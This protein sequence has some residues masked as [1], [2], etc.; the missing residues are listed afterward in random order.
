MQK[1]DDCLLNFVTLAQSEC[2]NECIVY[3]YDKKSTI[4][5]FADNNIKVLK[6]FPLINAFSVCFNSTKLLQTASQNFVAYISSV[7]NV[8]ALMDISK[9]V[10]NVSNTHLTG[11]QTTIAFIDTGINPHLDFCLGKNRI[12]KFY[13][14]VKNATIMHDDNGHGTFVAGVACGNGACSNGKYAGVA[15]KAN[16]ISLKALNEK[17]E[18]TAISILEAMQ[19]VF[20][21]YKKYNIK[22]V[23]MSFGSEP[24]G[25][26]DPI[27]LGAER[28]WE[29]GIVVVCAGGNS[30]P[31]VQSIKSP[32]ISR[33]IITVGGLDDKRDD[34][35]GF[36]FNKFDIA[37]FSS[38]GPALNRVKPDII[39]PSV[40]ITSCS[41]LGG[42][43]QMS[44]TSVATPMVAGIACLIFQKYPNATPNQIKKYMLANAKSIY[45]NRFAQ[46][47][48]VANF[49]FD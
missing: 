37:E 20:D 38:R 22:V 35:G 4:K 9:K 14:F 33:K 1:I 44:G 47:Y 43:K 3:Y 48:G 28:L 42:Y 13:D 23:C 21:N 30:G 25:L 32:G 15:S 41:H 45:K 8:F 29:E 49:T 11:E 26:N 12:I 40:N 36:D 39:A 5:Y 2:T 7:T 19:W 31:Q 18:A 27:M 34:E 16:I 10:I 24:L 46:G 6:E 17:G